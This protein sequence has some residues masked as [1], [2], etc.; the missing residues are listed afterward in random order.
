MIK[1]EFHD[2]LWQLFY[3]CLLLIYIFFMQMLVQAL[4]SRPFDFEIYLFIASFGITGFSMFLGIS[5][6]SGDRKQKALEY[7]MTLPISRNQLFWA[8]LAPRLIPVA[9][10]G[11]LFWLLSNIIVYP[12]LSSVALIFC[13]ITIVLFFISFSLSASADNLI[14]LFILSCFAVFLLSIICLLII[15]TCLAWKSGL[16]YLSFFEFSKMVKEFEFRIFT[17]LIMIALMVLSLF[18]SF[19]FSFIRFDIRSSSKFN[20]RQFKYIIPI[21]LFSIISSFGICYLGIKSQPVSKDYY[22]TKKHQLI[23]MH[24]HLGYFYIYDSNSVHWINDK[25]ISWEEFLIDENQYTYFLVKNEHAYSLARLNM[26]DLN[27]NILYQIPSKTKLSWHLPYIN[28]NREKF[29]LLEE[30]MNK[31]TQKEEQEY[32]YCEGSI[33]KRDS[34]NLVS[35]D[36]MSG[37]AKKIH[38]ISELFRN[39]CDPE[40]FGTDKINGK[41]FWLIRGYYRDSKGI[42]ML[43]IW[44]DGKIDDFGFFPYEPCYK[45]HLIFVPVSQGFEIRQLLDSG[46]KMIVKIQG[47]YAKIPLCDF[48]ELQD[49]KDIIILLDG[50]IFSLNLNNYNV[51]GIGPYIYYYNETYYAS[52]NEMFYI[53]YGRYWKHSEEIKWAKIYRIQDRK[54]TLLRQ[55]F[56]TD[57]VSISGYGIISYYDHRVIAYSFPDMQEL[58]FKYLR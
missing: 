50:K 5:A 31:L 20:K 21:M 30:N 16:I 10:F 39:Y 28:F 51:H 13:L 44:E 6:F 3:F 48:S 58:K 47:R 29:F 8:K 23:Q 57:K 35:I 46:T 27:Y 55:I 1:K 25:N 26:D 53:E 4:R 33:A 36:K 54:M 9:F 18:I 56:D 14:V 15:A 12:Y 34:L 11:L 49:A 41:Q 45:N 43:R 7:M 24:G 38:L 37:K 17:L 42:R 52:Y 2:I 22:L 40:I 19:C 32:Y